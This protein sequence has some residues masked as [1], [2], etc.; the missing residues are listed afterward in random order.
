MSHQ[1]DFY[2]DGRWTAA[3]LTSSSIGPGIP[4]LAV[5]LHLARAGRSVMV[6]DAGQP[7]WG[8]SGRNS[9][10]ISPDLKTTPARV[11]RD[12]GPVFGPRLVRDAWAAPDLVFAPIDH[13]GIA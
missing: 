6:L 5:A 8:A 11:E 2:I 4:G 12:F 9:G 3:T 7:G 10:Q 13:Y 1:Q